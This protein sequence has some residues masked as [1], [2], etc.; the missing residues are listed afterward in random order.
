MGNPNT[1]TKNL[2]YTSSIPHHC[3]YTTS[4]TKPPH[5]NR[6]KHSQK[7]TNDHAS[8]NYHH[9][10]NLHILFLDGQKSD[11][12]TRR[13]TPL[14]VRRRLSMLYYPLHGHVEKKENNRKACA[15]GGQ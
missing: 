3:R 9:I 15:L 2:C 4:N 10:R 6:Q 1:P 12:E 13:Q 8:I 5:Q 14:L 7:N 11:R